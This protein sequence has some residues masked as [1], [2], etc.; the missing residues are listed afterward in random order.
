MRGREGSLEGEDGV[1]RTCGRGDLRRDSGPEL[2]S[3]PVDA[4]FRIM[5]ITSFVGLEGEV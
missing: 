2:S 4:G 3:I 5:Q 1:G